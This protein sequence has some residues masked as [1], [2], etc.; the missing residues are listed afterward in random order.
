MKSDSRPERKFWQI[1]LADLERQ[2]GADAKRPYRRPRPLC[3]DC[4]MAPMRWKSGAVCLC[5]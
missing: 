2:L 5:R 3:V 1:A 4:A